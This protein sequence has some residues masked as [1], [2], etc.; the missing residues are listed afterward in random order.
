M[1]D[2]PMIPLRELLTR[3]D[4]SWKAKGLAV[5]ISMMSN[6]FKQPGTNKI[7]LLVQHGPEAETS[8]R[9]GL[10]ELESAGILQIHTLRTAER[11]GHVTGSAWDI[12]V[13]WKGE[14]NA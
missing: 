14:Q 4:L 10:R 1:T 12:K 7:Q 13:V 9:S 3:K 11:S 6:Q 2:S 8:I 5:I